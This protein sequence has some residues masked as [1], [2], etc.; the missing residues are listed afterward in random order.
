MRM[1]KTGVRTLGRALLSLLILSG[2][3]FCAARLAPGDPLAAYYGQRAERLTA[4][5]R[6]RAE[7]TPAA[8]PERR[9]ILF[10]GWRR[11]AAG[12]RS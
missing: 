4:E 8:E 11:W 10:P 12:R 1:I 5:E 9:T 7:E 2:V 3:V 6:V